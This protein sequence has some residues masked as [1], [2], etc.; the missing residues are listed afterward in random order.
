[1]KGLDLSHYTL[2]IGVA[3]ALLAGCGGSQPP[4]GPPGATEQSLATTSHDGRG[5]LQRTFSLATG[6]ER[7]GKIPYAGGLSRNY[8]VLFRFNGVDGQGP[9]QLLNVKGTLYGTTFLG[10]ARKFR[11]GS[12]GSFGCGTVFSITT[13]GS[14]R[15]L[16]SFGG[17]DDGALPNRDLLN[18]DGTLYGTTY[19]GGTGGSGSLGCGTVFSVTTSGKERVLYNFTGGDDGC[20]PVA[21]LVNVNGTLYG[22]TG[23][24]GRHLQ[25]TV[26]S[27][28]T[29]GKERVLYNFGDKPYD[30][31]E[32]AAPLLDVSGTLYGTTL[33]GGTGVHCRGTSGCGTMFSI[34]TAGKERVLHSFAVNPH[35]GA[36]PLAPL[37]DVNGTLY[38]T[39]PSGGAH[40]SRCSTFCGGTA[41]SI[42]TAGKEHVLHSFAGSPSDGSYPVAGLLNFNGTLYGTTDRGGAY[43]CAPYPGC[44][45]VFSITTTGKERV[46]YSFAGMPDGEAPAGGLI[47]LSRRLYGTTGSGG[48]KNNGTVFTLK[49]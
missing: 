15:R 3:A 46:L 21:G 39:T 40:G 36:L 13:T 4:I 45:T 7:G 19:Q 24:Q 37:I 38:G 16:H 2:S 23:Y 32:S 26:F 30:G 8:S 9:Q 10:G 29:A 27:V 41:F 1:M 17:R 44:V 49:P 22:T 11:D 12:C 20:S 33:Q 28:T 31:N 34:T 35:D 5:G 48:E 14:E 47:N 25:G 18:V 6:R 43:D 42:T